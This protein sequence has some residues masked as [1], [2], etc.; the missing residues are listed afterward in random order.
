LNGTVKDDF[1]EFDTLRTS[2][3]P[4]MNQ[5]FSTWTIWVIVSA[6]NVS[7][8]IFY[9]KKKKDFHKGKG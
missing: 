2:K 7:I 9:L 4:G 1:S 3:K 5:I 6:T 8:L